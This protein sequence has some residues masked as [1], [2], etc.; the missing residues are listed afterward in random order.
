MEVFMVKYDIKCMIKH[1]IM[2][3][4]REILQDIFNCKFDNMSP[5]WLKNPIDGSDIELDGFNPDIKTGIGN[6]LAFM[7]Q[8]NSIHKPGEDK[9]MYDHKIDEYRNTICMR[10]DILLIKIPE[11]VIDADLRRYILRKL[12]MHGLLHINNIN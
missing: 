11:F 10:K 6:G 12:N 1:L 9:Y 7:Y 8:T 3:K 5:V 2:D 4:C